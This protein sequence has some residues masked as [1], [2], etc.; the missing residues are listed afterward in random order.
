[1][2]FTSIFPYVLLTIMLIRG[3]TLPG[4]ALGIEFY[5]IPD[6]SKLA[7][8]GVIIFIMHNQCNNILNILLIKG[9]NKDN[10]TISQLMNFLKKE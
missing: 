4:A 6:W 10:T 9:M 2:Y 7:D 1:M 3:V 8:A 5:L